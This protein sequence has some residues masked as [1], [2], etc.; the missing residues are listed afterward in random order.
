M[1]ESLKCTSEPLFVFSNVISAHFTPRT[2]KA[3]PMQIDGEPWMQPPC[4]VSTPLVLMAASCSKCPQWSSIHSS[5]LSLSDR[6]HTQESSQYADGSAGQ[7]IRFFHL[8]MKVLPSQHTCT[9]DTFLHVCKLRANQTIPLHTFHCG[10]ID[11][12]QI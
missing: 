3:L 1:H 2:K 5:H 9:T 6:D 8:Q 7:I 4:T 10:K 12:D 11:L